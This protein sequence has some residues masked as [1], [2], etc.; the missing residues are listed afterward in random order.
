MPLPGQ[1]T[2]PNLTDLIR[3]GGSLQ[4][5][6]PEGLQSLSAK[7]GRA[8]PPTTPLS[9]S[10]IG[11]NAHQAKMAG[12]K[13]QVL[14]ALRASV[15][16]TNDLS[17]ALRAAPAAPQAS[18]VDTASLERAKKLEG[19]SSLQDR[20]GE[21]KNQML[22]QAGTSAPQTQLYDTSKAETPEL[23]D[24]LSRLN[25]NPKDNQA[26]L[27]ANTA[28]SS[29]GFGAGNLVTPEV[30]LSKYGTDV[31]KTAASHIR[32]PTVA[33]LTPAQLSGLGFGSTDELG[34]TLGLPPGGAAGLTMT[35]LTD[36]VNQVVASDYS[37]TAQLS[38]Q[39]NDPFA[40]AAARADARNQLRALGATG[41]RAAETEV[42]K[43]AEDLTSGLTVQFNGQ[44][45]TLDQALSSNNVGKFI[46][47]YVNGTQEDKNKLKAA[48][49]E[50][51]ALV[52]KYSGVINAANEQSKAGSK[53]F[54]DIQTAIANVA[55]LGD[56][57][58]VSSDLLDKLIPGHADLGTVVPKLAEKSP[59]L[60]SLLGDPNISGLDKQN[61]VTLLSSILRTNPKL[62]DSLN[63]TQFGE[64]RRLGLDQ[65]GDA[66]NRF[67]GRATNWSYVNSLGDDS[68]PDAVSRA[69]GFNSEKELEDSVKEA[70]LMEASGLFGT[71]DHGL[72]SLSSNAVLDSEGKL[73]PSKTVAKLRASLPDASPGSIAGDSWNAP[74][75]AVSKLGTYVGQGAGNK[76]YQI[77]HD[78]LPGGISEVEMQK[79]SPSINS[80]NYK[81]FTPLLDTMSPGAKN[82]LVDD[83]LADYTRPGFGAGVAGT[84]NMLQSTT[85][86]TWD[87]REKNLRSA[88]NAQFAISD[89]MHNAPTD[90]LRSLMKKRLDSLSTAIAAYEKKQPPGAGVAGFGEDLEA[91]P[92]SAREPSSATDAGTSSPQ[93]NTSDMT[94]TDNGLGPMDYTTGGYASAADKRA[95]ELEYA[96]SADKRAQDLATAS[97]GAGLTGPLRA[98]L[99]N[100]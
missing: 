94:G 5:T 52:D 48:E 90:E 28:M 8:A 26:W 33:D 87:A 89:A 10:G 65:P 56:G 47:S 16:G 62:F 68:S 81:D 74:G 92:Q 11:A 59:L 1:P 24:A 54:S 58:K 34:T 70:K 15:E 53:A 85:P 69:F 2:Q 45:M 80:G 4:Q 42:D 77:V 49:P 41:V 83:V 13:A 100:P 22:T 78:V 9:A 51:A 67:L 39:A 27:D 6:S 96:S 71:G 66:Q 91:V 29:Q 97:A 84:V 86:P 72:T 32:Q 19:I 63:S 46:D 93:Y 82:T 43:M 18:A 99:R 38:Q 3:V 64:L 7:I 55:D 14:P 50:M 30:L 37:H 75:E 79:I 95:A 60:G 31:G 44:S 88:V 20:V 36:R 17:T 98:R 57:V 76:T 35:Q 12:T 73:D 61:A 23:A 25:A 40:G 21:L